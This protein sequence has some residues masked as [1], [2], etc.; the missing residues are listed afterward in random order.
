M[1]PRPSNKR[2]ADDHGHDDEHFSEGGPR[3]ARKILDNQDE[4]EELE[5]DEGV[6]VDIPSPTIAE[7]GPHPLTHLSIHHPSLFSQRPKPSR[8]S[9]EC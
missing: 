1:D 9:S 5:E 7:V 8:K 2:H 4:E 3:K 6:D